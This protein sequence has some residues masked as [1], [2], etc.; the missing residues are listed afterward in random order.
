MTMFTDADTD[1]SED[2]ADDVC[3][4]AEECEMLYQSVVDPNVSLIEQE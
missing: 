2:Y 3:G 1:A 4:V